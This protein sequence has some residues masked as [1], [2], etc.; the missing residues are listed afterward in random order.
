MIKDLVFSLLLFMY[1]YTWV[2]DIFNDI[3]V[4]KV[5]H[6]MRLASLILA[7]GVLLRL[8]FK[9]STKAKGV[10]LQSQSKAMTVLLFF[11][12][13]LLLDPTYRKVSI[14]I[15]IPLTLTILFSRKNTFKI[16]AII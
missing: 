7:I 1:S 9:N 4:Y 6:M 2:T 3:Q 5:A 13:V 12:L 16:S 11:T 15:S 8:F 10:K 14:Y